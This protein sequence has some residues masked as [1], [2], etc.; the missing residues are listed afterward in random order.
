MTDLID[1][2]PRPASLT[3]LRSRSAP[4]EPLTLRQ[5]WK[6]SR[7]GIPQAGDTS[8]IE[9]SLD[10][11]G[12]DPLLD[13][14]LHRVEISLRDRGQYH[15]IVRP[16]DPFSMYVYLTPSLLQALIAHGYEIPTPRTPPTH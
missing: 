3:R 1:F 14:D 13:F 11:F 16:K 10:D 6:L 12:D 8:W 9:D 4:D 7:I 5:V 2:T 15:L